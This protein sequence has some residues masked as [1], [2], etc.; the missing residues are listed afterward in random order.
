MVNIV[1]EG[2]IE[3]VFQYD[4]VLVGIGINNSFSNGFAYDIGLNF[5]DVKDAVNSVSN[6]LDRRNLGTV[7]TVKHGGVVFCACYVHGGG[8]RK[9]ENG[10]FVDY[11]A[12][13]KCLR[14]VHEL[15]KGKKIA[16]TVIGGSRYDGNGGREKIFSIFS[17]VFDDCDIWVYDYEQET[18]DDVMY[19]RLVDLESRK[20]RKEID[21]PE[22]EKEK[23]AICWKRKNGIF[24]EMPEDFSCRKAPVLPENI[25][26]VS[27]KDLEK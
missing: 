17:E 19:R 20:R 11:S 10:E 27:R 15:Y 14:K 9:S 22:Y 12:V 21:F 23:N 26:N 25:I 6:Y 4:V 2:L 16:S 5:P 7:V 24:K 13:K 3:K 1:N 18:F 8:Y